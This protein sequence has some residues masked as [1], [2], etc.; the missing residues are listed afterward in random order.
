[1]VRNCCSQYKEG[2]IDK[3]YNKNQNI[4][5]VLGVRKFES[6]KRAKFDYIMDH[7]WSEKIFGT[8]NMS[9]N[10][11]RFAPVVEWK[12]EDVWLYI[13]REGLIY[14][15]Q[16]DLGFNRCGCLIC[17]YQND[18]ID[19]L[20]QEY[21]PKMWNRWLGI[22]E[23]NYTFCFIKE[24][25]KWTL[26][27]WQQGRWKEAKSKEQKLIDQKCTLERIDELSN[28]KGISIQMAKKFF[29][30]VCKCGKK[31]NP[32]ELAMFY[33]TY[34]RFDTSE[35][36]NREL[37]CKKCF[38]VVEGLSVKEYDIKYREYRDSGCELF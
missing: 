7:D 8:D 24:N 21:S 37:L 28:I 4:T 25:L 29:D 16:Y 12:D 30:K 9:A 2:Q 5:M 26:E 13:L 33:K 34:G 35:E 36:D 10:W 18:Y 27:E 20:T 31:M 1:M 23:K 19:L 32:S 17:P 11:I 3:T 22:L 14:N 6:T 38:C 15:R